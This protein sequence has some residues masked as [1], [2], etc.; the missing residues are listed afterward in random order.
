M[1]KYCA[2]HNVTLF[3]YLLLFVCLAPLGG[4]W[5][6]SSPTRV[7]LCTLCRCLSPLGVSNTGS[8]GN[9]PW[10]Y[11]KRWL[12]KMWLV[13]MRT[14]LELSGPLYRYDQCPCE[15]LHTDMCTGRKP[16]ER[17]GGNLGDVPTCHQTSGISRKAQESG[18]E[19]QSM[20]SS[21]PSEGA[22]TAGTLTLDFKLPELW[23]GTFLLFKLPSLC[24]L[25]QQPQQTS[26][27]TYSITFR[28][29]NH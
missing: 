6:L 19:A 2:T 17:E 3:G 16:S 4:R 14:Y 5:D 25:L 10:P 9:F 7:R 15:M 24:T 27:I 1:L 20:S 12:L 8:P 11:L 28:S 22:Y 13:K 23:E 18:R 29:N 21:S 26:T